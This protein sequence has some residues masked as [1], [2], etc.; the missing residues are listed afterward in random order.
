ME[1]NGH[2]EVRPLEERIE[3]Q[4]E[5]LRAQVES[6]D[7]WLRTFA[8]ERP[9]LAIGCAVGLGFLIGRIASKKA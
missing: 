7:T 3:D 2:Q 4:L 6:A 9:L 1:G 8:R 5:G